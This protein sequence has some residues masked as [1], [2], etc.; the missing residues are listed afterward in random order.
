MKTLIACLIFAAIGVAVALTINER[1]YGHYEPAFGPISYRGDIDASNAMATLEKEWS[2]KLPKVEL[3]DGHTF[4]FGVMRPDEKGEHVFVVKNV[5]DES[6][7]LK[8]GA[9]TCKCTVGELGD[10]SLEPGEQTEVT[11]SWTVLTSENTFG[12]SAELRTNDPNNIAIRFEIKGTVVRDVKLFPEEVLLGDVAAG[13][14]IPFDVNVFSFMDAPMD[15]GEIKIIDDPIN[16]LTDF[17][18]TP[19]EPSE[20]DGINATASQGFHVHGT[21]HPGLKQGP[22]T[23][24]VML[25]LQAQSSDEASADDNENAEA[26]ESQG[27]GESSVG[28][29]A[30]YIPVSGR[31]VGA[32]S[33]LPNSRLKGVSGGGYVFDFGILGKDDPLTAKAFVR[34]KGAEHADA[35]LSIGEIKPAENV[36]A[37]LG[38]PIRQGNMTLF[39]LELELKPG[40]VAIDRLGMNKGDYG[41]VMIESDDPLVPALKLILKFALP[42]R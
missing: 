27:E 2:K 14:D 35:K 12:Q 38:E 33:M 1:R 9:S 4:D 30:V 25:T 37:K 28:K 32:L 34:L 26:T 29:R 5:G 24:S 11:M 13:E 31:I 20:Q 6:L 23:S 15:A 18:V 19:F 7:V 16:E 36:E 3:P 39:P 10:E 21:I 42:A 8:V 22:I 41:S 17:E 40:T